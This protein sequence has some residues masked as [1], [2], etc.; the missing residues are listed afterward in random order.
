MD[1]LALLTY[2]LYSEVN[3]FYMKSEDNSQNCMQMVLD[4]G[5]VRKQRNLP[6]NGA[7]FASK[8]LQFDIVG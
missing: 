4:S 7:N 3:P 1:V 2:R 5:S 6:Q 8:F